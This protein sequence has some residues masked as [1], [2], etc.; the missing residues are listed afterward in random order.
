MSTLAVTHASTSVG[1]G[2]RALPAFAGALS[3]SAAIAHFGVV[4]PHWRDWWAHGA[5]FVVSGALQ[6]LLAAL[7]VRRPRDWVALL[8]IGGNLA[9]ITGYVYSRTN[10]VPVGPHGGVPEDVGFLD[11][12]TT[13][14]EVATVVALVAMLGGRAGRWAMN[15]IL[16]FGAGLWIGR[17]TGFIL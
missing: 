5:F 15:L 9:V 10:G 4:E 16:L 7:L 3:L 13:A 8:G 6:T 1:K 2:V 12:S 14:I 11:F 17:A